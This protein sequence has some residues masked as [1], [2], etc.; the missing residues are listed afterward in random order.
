MSENVGNTDALCSLISQVKEDWTVRVRDQY[1]PKNEGTSVIEKVSSDL[2]GRGPGY[3]A[4]NDR[5]TRYNI[6]PV[7]GEDFE[8]SG[9]TLRIYNPKHAPVEGVRALTQEYTFSPPAH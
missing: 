6:W 5:R 9:R 2:H 3:M 7:D 8:V 4:T 1:E